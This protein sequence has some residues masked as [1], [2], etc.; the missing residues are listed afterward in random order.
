[1]IRRMPPRALRPILLAAWVLVAAAPALAK[2]RGSD[3]D[4]VIVA[5]PGRFGTIEEAA[6]AERQVDWWDGATADD[7]ACTESF[8]AVEL[9]RYLASALHV[10]PATIRLARPSGAPDRG[11]VIA[12]GTRRSNPLFASFAIPGAPASP[13]GEGFRLARVARDHR[14]LFA[15]EGASR[16]GALY[17]TYRFLEQLGV[18]FFGLG[19]TGTVIPAS[20]ALPR[21]LDV[22]EAPGYETR[23]FWAWEPRADRDFLLWMARNRL[24]LWTAEERDPPFLAKLGIRLVAGGHAIQK[25]CLDPDRYAAAHPEWYGMVDGRRRPEIGPD[26]GVNFCTSNVEAVRTLAGNLAHEVCAGRWRRADALA[27]W[28]LDDGH[29]CECD[30]C[31]A[32]GPPSDRLFALLGVIADSLRAARAQG[33]LQRPLHV[34]TLAFLETMS[35]PQR[36][37]ANLEGQDFAVTYFPMDRC[38]AH[39]L[40]DSSCAEIN[41]AFASE[42]LA[43]AS[44]ADRPYRGALEVG[45]YYNIAELKSLP[46]VLTR[47]IRSDVPWY[48]AHGARHFHAM[49]VVTR[50]WGPW[51]VDHVLLARLLWSP[52]ADADSILADFWAREY[53]TT[54]PQARRFHEHLEAATADFK[55]LK[56]RVRAGRKL[57]DLRWQLQDRGYPFVLDHLQPPGRE[58]PGLERFGFPAMEREM[59][60]AGLALDSARAACRDS[61]ESVRL[62][63]DARRFDYGSATL[64]FYDRLLRVYT[65]HTEGN[66]SAARAEWPR[67]AAV[68]GRLRGMTDVVAGSSSQANAS[69]GFEATRMTAAYDSFLRLYGS[70]P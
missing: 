37:P 20:A 9:Q 2:P 46:V 29:W 52:N 21:R 68:A 24:N 39:A 30:A 38:Y 18:R 48:F 70:G 41:R 66:E 57:F 60:A 33:R 50:L 67:L 62:A 7:D 3:A 14:T 13:S 11:V 34:T 43:W 28:M 5:D 4:I 44:G 40:P 58:R 47:V 8:A 32:L 35:P 6:I 53:P 51:T 55:L 31:R 1:M 61:F 12:I 26:A 42:Y 49:H 54:G 17:G 25:V 36:V 23:G 63:E 64:E 56:H 45:E 19:D 59:R 16:V 22:A 27:V 10:D 15:I 65:L 69:D